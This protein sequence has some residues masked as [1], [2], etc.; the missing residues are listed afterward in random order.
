MVEQAAATLTDGGFASL[1]VSWLAESEDDPDE[2]LVGWLEGSGC[3]AWVIGLEGADPLEHAAG[4]N[5][6]LAP[7]PA[8]Y[9]AALDEWT[10]YFAQLG[11]GWI[12][13]GAVLLH[14]RTARKQAIRLDSADADELDFA[15]DQ[16]ARVFASLAR[17]DTLDDDG[18]LDEIVVLAP[19]TSGST[20]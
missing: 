12:S 20:A 14:R 10:A 2:R 5:E 17:L 3:D 9:G 1:L 18:L 6:H 13:E 11:I 15:S 4:W 7:D 16:I 8:A 19:R